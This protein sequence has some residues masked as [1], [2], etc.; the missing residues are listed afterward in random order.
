MSEYTSKNGV[1]FVCIAA[2]VLFVSSLWAEETSPPPDPYADAQ[3]LV[4]AFVVKVSTATLKEMGVDP[5]GQGSNEVSIL[6]LSAC[7]QKDT[8]H[9]VSGAK[10]F[11]RQKKNGVSKES[12][13]VYY[14]SVFGS[15]VT[16]S[17]YEFRKELAGSAVIRS[18]RKVTV[19]Y[20]YSE[21]GVTPDINHYDPND[22][23]PTNPYNYSWKS[24]LVLVPGQ[25]VIAG[26]I[27]NQ[28]HVIFLVLTATIQNLPEAK[29]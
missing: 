4:E 15:G 11:I 7:L 27:Q 20:I 17:P 5:L 24:Q 22:A 23:A 18:D 3:A 25:P 28:D 1:V 12:K 2:S 29:P 19:E 10:V 8:A 6:K 21:S 9:V 16:F 14:K 26:A 13:T